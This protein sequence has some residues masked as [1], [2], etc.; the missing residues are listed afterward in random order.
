MRLFAVFSLLFLAQFEAASFETNETRSE[1]GTEIGGDQNNFDVDTV[2]NGRSI[3]DTLIK[4]NQN[5]HHVKKV[6]NGVRSLVETNRT[7]SRRIVCVVAPCT[8][9]DFFPGVVV[10]RDTLNVSRLLRDTMI[11]GNQNN[12]HVLEVLNRKRETEHTDFNRTAAQT[13]VGEKDN[14]KVDVVVRG[15]SIPE[16]KQLVERGTVI[17]GNQNNECVDSVLNKR[18][19]NCNNDNGATSNTEIRGNQNNDVVNL[20]NN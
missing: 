20:V 1:R 11:R 9:T 5:N 6:Q 12:N 17:G 19:A 4:G 18:S 14:S 2:K 13:M 7:L 15:S 8:S 16:T 3:R 10:R